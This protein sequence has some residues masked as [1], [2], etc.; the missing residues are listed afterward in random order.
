MKTKKPHNLLNTT[1]KLNNA[2]N[3]NCQFSKLCV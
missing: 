3:V 1:E 2:V